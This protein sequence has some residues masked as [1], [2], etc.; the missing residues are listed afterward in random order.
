MFIRRRFTRG[1]SIR[2]GFFAWALLYLQQ[3]SHDERF[4]AVISVADA[5]RFLG[6]GVA[7]RSG[8]LAVFAI[9]SEGHIRLA[10]VPRHEELARSYL[11]AGEIADLL[12]ADWG[13]EPDDGGAC[14]PASPATGRERILTSL[15]PP[16][17][18]TSTR[19][20][21]CSEIACAL[22]VPYGRNFDQQRLIGSLC[23]NQAGNGLAIT[24]K[25]KTA[26]EMMVFARYVMFSEVYWHHGVRSATAMLQR[27]FY[28]LHDRLDLVSLFRLTEG[29]LSGGAAIARGGLSGG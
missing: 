24:D 28:L 6:R 2:W 8:A 5:Q 4:A 17:R 14:W 13:V 27:A 20:T 29:P 1:L 21:T 9:R 15:L 3:L 16:G 22:G 10:G 23:L 26:A 25:G 19:W 12:W 18:S 7:A 11:A